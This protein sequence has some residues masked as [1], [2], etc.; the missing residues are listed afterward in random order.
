MFPECSFGIDAEALQEVA[1]GVREKA[2]IW[3]RGMTR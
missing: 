3:P 2:S 1:D